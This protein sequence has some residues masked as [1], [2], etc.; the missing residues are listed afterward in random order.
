MASSPS[1]KPADR[2]IRAVQKRLSPGRSLYLLLDFD[3]TLAPLR[4]NPLHVR[5]PGRK[6]DVLRALVRRHDVRLAF[7]SGRTVDQLERLVPLDGAVYCGAYGSQNKWPGG[8]VRWRPVVR[9]HRPALARLIRKLERELTGYKGLILEDKWGSIGVQTRAL[10][11]A[12]RRT[13]AKIVRRWWRNAGW[14]HGPDGVNPFA[15][16]ENAFGIEVRPRDFDKGS[17]VRELLEIEWQR[18][19]KPL[20]LFL[21]DDLSDEDAF[22]VLRVIGI[23]VRV[24]NGRKTAARYRL[25]SPSEVWGLFRK[26]LRVL[27]QERTNRRA[28]PDSLSSRDATP[29]SPARR[30][31]E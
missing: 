17:M 27:D 2:I 14:V 4:P 28:G 16:V 9:R 31:S 15:F 7:V 21:G 19:G 5:S 25:G 1:S 26:L 11:P 6:L 24:G 10:P 3:G 13:V 29:R 22:R 8:S 30:K 18:G 23:T 12:D 20:P